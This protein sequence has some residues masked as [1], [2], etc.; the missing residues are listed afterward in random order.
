[1]GSFASRNIIRT[2]RLENKNGSKKHWKSQIILIL[3]GQN[4]SVYG[5][6]L[7]EDTK[8]RIVNVKFERKWSPIIRQYFDFVDAK[9]FLGE[10]GYQ[11]YI[12][13]NTLKPNREVPNFFTIFYLP[14][15][16]LTVDSKDN[17]FVDVV[18]GRVAADV[19]VGPILVIKF[20]GFVCT[21][22]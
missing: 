3:A 13:K 20:Q 2:C 5:I 8:P 21:L 18:T 9:E 12:T 15:K 11:T 6:F 22:I 19:W 7:A 14:D 17:N 16:F 10:I 4:E 1:M